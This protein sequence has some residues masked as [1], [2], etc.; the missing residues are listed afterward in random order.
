MSF[1]STA[2]SFCS[3]AKRPEVDIPVTY[4]LAQFQAGNLDRVMLKMLGTW[5]ERQCFGALSAGLRMPFRAG[6]RCRLSPGTGGFEAL[7]HR[8]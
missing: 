3:F 4:L 1:S 2:A 6:W 5:A 8:H 7:R